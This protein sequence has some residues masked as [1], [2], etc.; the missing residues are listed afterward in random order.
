MV[1]I[2]ASTLAHCPLE[3]L[4]ASSVLATPSLRNVSVLSNESKR[5][6][7]QD[8]GQCKRHTP[9]PF[10]LN[11]L[12]IHN[13]Q[14][15][16]ECCFWC[17]FPRDRHRMEY[18]HTCLLIPEKKQALRDLCRPI[19]LKILPLSSVPLIYLISS[20][21]SPRSEL[22]NCKVL[23]NR[24]G[25]EPPVTHGARELHDRWKGILLL[26]PSYLRHLTHGL[27]CGHIKKSFSSSLDI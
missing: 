14:G 12:Q 9:S 21:H 11:E 4:P 15:F 3:R 10:S 23:C 6:V 17:V 7:T 22:H 1:G 25:A 20:G 27:I 19:F 8:S 24:L 26:A 16:C 5:H 13:G 18:F 2:L